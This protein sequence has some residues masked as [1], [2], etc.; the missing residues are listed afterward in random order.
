MSNDALEAVGVLFSRGI[1]ILLVILFWLCVG[2]WMR[3]VLERLQEIS[4]R[5]G[6]LVNTNGGSIQ[7]TKSN[8][9]AVTFRKRKYALPTSTAMH[10]PACNNSLPASILSAT[11]PI[12]PHCQAELSVE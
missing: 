2:S 7:E 6:Q 1:A 4:M 12:C 8:K 10:C 3:S 5:L 9:S 11:A